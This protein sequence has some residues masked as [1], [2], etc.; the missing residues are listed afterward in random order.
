MSRS[1]EDYVRLAEHY[2]AIGQE[3]IKLSEWDE[4]PWESV[5]GCTDAGVTRG[6]QRC[7][8]KFEAAHECGLTF[9]WTLDPSA[10]GEWRGENVLAALKRLPKRYALMIIAIAEDN[11]ENTRKRIKEDSE[12]LAAMEAAI[13]E[14]G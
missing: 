11:A 10:W 14:L 5:T 7:C 8:M 12:A 1:I 2:K 6:Q 3:K 9:C 4:L 13:A